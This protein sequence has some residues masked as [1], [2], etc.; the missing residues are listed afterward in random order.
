V[1][2]SDGDGTTGLTTW[3]GLTSHTKSS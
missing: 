3:S 1:L 2:E